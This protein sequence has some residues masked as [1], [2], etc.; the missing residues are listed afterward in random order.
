MWLAPF[1]STVSS[2]ALRVYYRL[3][4]GGGI[5]PP[6]G[7]VL[8][9]A[10]HPNSL[11]DPAMVALAARR[12]VRFLAK[13]PLFTDPLVGFLVR[14]AG[15]IPVYRK[16]DDPS[17]VSRN[18]DAFRAVYDVLATGHVVGIFP[19]GISHSEPGMA[20]LKTGAARIA[21]GAAERLGQVIS[22]VPVGLSFRAK[23]IF[24]S[25]AY[26][27]RGF[28]LAWG[29]LALRGPDDA[30]VV[31]ELTARIDSALR[32]VTVNLVEWED[33]P[34]V[35]C[36]IR[37]W[38]AERGTPSQAAERLKRMEFTT[39]MLARIRTTDDPDGAQL[40]ADVRRHDRRMRW[41]GLRPADLRADVGTDRAVT[42]A[43]RRMFLFFPLLIVLAVLGAMLF[44]VPYQLTGFV[45]RQLQL[46]RDVQSTW[47][48]LIGTVLYG[49][50][51]LALVWLVVG[52]LGWVAALAG[53]VLIPAAG[54]VGLHVR[55]NWRTTVDDV[56]RF[57]LLRSRRSL[58]DRLRD[59]QRDLAA[60]L[61]ALR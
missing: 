59:E 24:R 52:S 38:E 15:S 36:A 1:L 21:L 3:H 11:L 39:K 5:V 48:L 7:P 44:W 53:L 56:R 14:G 42:W 41:L 17:Q 25:D 43:G 4:R 37:V 49:G 60:R 10:N 47:K 18:E 27:V 55:E 29:D 26:V 31:R 34:L 2:A 46:Q 12:P 22:I 19:E 57:V 13:A 32:T 40:I 6:N 30:E 16:S 28:P 33:Q 9:V 54:I 50:W 61:D 45:V 51:L 35:E 20:P 58:V 23:E 8:L